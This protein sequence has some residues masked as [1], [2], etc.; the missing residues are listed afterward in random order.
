MNF[1]KDLDEG[2]KRPSSV[3][4]CPPLPN[5]LKV[6][7][8]MQMSVSAWS[9]ITSNGSSLDAVEKG[10]SLCEEERCDGTVGYG[11]R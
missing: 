10:C 9:V 5:L 11:G 8:D 2:L 1:T 7:S 3:F 4:I 6:L